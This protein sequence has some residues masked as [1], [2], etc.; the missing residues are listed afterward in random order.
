MTPDELRVLAGIQSGEIKPIELPAPKKKLA[1]M[2]YY[3]EEYAEFLK[4]HIFARLLKGDIVTYRDVQGRSR[5]TVSCLLSQARKYLFEHMDPS[6]EY[7]AIWKKTRVDVD[8]RGGYT[9]S[10]RTIGMGIAES[11]EKVIKQ[12][13]I[14]YLSSL[15]SAEEGRAVFS[16]EGLKLTPE[17]V[18]E[19]QGMLEQYK[20]LLQYAVTED[21]IVIINLPPDDKARP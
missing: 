7:L 14:K 11:V 5:N 1:V 19:Y 13:I 2:P 18:V 4:V 21:Q 10:R 12:D 8:H 9:F 17:E 6:G 15:T 16:R 20:E 3:K